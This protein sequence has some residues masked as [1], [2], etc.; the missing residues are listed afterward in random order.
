MCLVMVQESMAQTAI[1][2]A[3]AITLESG[4]LS[5]SGNADFTDGTF[6][7]TGGDLNVGGTLLGVTTVESGQTVNLTPL[8]LK[9][10]E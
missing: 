4:A 7:F 3:G 1:W 5:V 9:M 10:P 6:T 2:D 8:L